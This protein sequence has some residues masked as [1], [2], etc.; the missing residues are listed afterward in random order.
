[1]LLILIYLILFTFSLVGAATCEAGSA[2]PQLSGSTVSEPV[3]GC[4]CSG[5]S[6]SGCCDTICCSCSCHVPP[7]HSLRII[8]APTVMVQSFHEPSWS[9][10]LVY[11][12]IY[13][14]PQNVA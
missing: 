6:G 5:E 1:M 3:D 14:P 13:V 2:S 4:P 9:L 12:T 11:R 10:P 8:Y 7:G